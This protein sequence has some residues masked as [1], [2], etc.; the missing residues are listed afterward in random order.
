LLTGKD[1]RIFLENMAKVAERKVSPEEYKV[2]KA[3]YERMKAI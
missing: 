2:I 1:A 3:N